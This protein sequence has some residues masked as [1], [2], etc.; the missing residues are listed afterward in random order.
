MQ[1][2]ASVMPSKSDDG[3]IFNA[4]PKPTLGVE[5]ELQIIDPSTGAAVNRAQDVFKALNNDFFYKTEL[6]Q[7]I[8]EITT[9]V[10]T[11]VADVEKDL[12]GKLKKMQKALCATCASENCTDS[13]DE[14]PATQGTLPRVCKCEVHCPESRN[15]IAAMQ[16]V[17]NRI[18]VST[19][20]W[21]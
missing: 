2:D 13:N 5:V 11:D 12:G 7:S 18:V 1:L 4:S 14:I 19:N 10:C 20:N 16:E 21:A 8:V 6:F 9:D 3:I 17:D 15:E